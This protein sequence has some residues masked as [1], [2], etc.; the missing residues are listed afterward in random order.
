MSGTTDRLKGRAKQAAGVLVGDE[1]LERAGKVDRVAGRIE[2]AAEEF[3]D[4][5]KS[6]I[7]RRPAK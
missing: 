1:R 4:K 7:K 2:Q 6:T 5:V 3:V